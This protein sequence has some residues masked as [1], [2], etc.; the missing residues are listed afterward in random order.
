MAFIYFSMRSKLPIY[1][2]KINKKICPFTGVYGFI[3]P[4]WKCWKNKIPLKTRL[5]KIQKHPYMGDFASIFSLMLKNLKSRSKSIRG[6]AAF[7]LRF[8]SGRHSRR[9][10]FR[11]CGAS[12]TRSTAARLRGPDCAVLLCKTACPTG[13]V[14]EAPPPHAFGINKNFLWAGMKCQMVKIKE[15]LTG[16]VFG[17]LTVISR[18][19]DRPPLTVSRSTRIKACWNCQCSCGEKMVFTRNQVLEPRHHTCWH[20]KPNP[21]PSIRIGMEFGNL[22]VTAPAADHITPSGIHKKQWECECTCGKKIIAQQ[23]RLKL[24]GV[25]HCG[26]QRR[27]SPNKDKPITYDLSV[28]KQSEPNI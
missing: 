21:K 10:S 3:F 8:H 9:S 1:H 13:P 23:I 4:W 24:G 11:S 27:N 2:G 16:K 18:A 6:A 14:K 17:S 15:D 7:R 19:P 5:I 12:L 20:N 26:C 22:K 25:T 28:D